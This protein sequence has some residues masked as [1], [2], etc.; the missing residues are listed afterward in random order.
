MDDSISPLKYNL[1]APHSIGYLFRNSPKGKPAERLGR[2][3][4]DPHL[5]D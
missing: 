3:G 1:D 2:K 4:A 5:T